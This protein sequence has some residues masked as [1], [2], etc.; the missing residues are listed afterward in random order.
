MP[1]LSWHSFGVCSQMPLSRRRSLLMELCWQWLWVH[2]RYHILPLHLQI[3]KPLYVF[4]VILFGGTVYISL[5]V[6]LGVTTTIGGPSIPPS[7]IK[8][9]PL[10]VLTSIW[11]ALWVVRFSPF[12]PR[13]RHIVPLSSLWSSCHTSLS[14]F[15]TNANPWSFMSLRL[16]PLFSRNL[17]GCFW[18]QWYVSYVFQI[19]STTLWC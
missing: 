2:L 4:S 15:W 1:A 16:S 13:L 6:A 7:T 17:N 8:S 14:M 9:I 10:F 3:F 5:D 19:N 12:T 18:V 11:P